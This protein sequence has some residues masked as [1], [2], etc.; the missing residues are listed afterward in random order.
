MFSHGGIQCCIPSSSI[1]GSNCFTLKWSIFY[2]SCTMEDEVV[3]PVVLVCVCLMS[4][5]SSI[6]LYACWPLIHLLWRNVFV[7]FA[8]IPVVFFVSLLLDCNTCLWV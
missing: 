7:S 3:L 8:H 5:D 4:S 6:L 1:I 2:C